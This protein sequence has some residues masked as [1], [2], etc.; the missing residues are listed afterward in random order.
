M[1]FFTQILQIYAE[2]NDAL[3]LEWIVLFNV[4]ESVALGQN[5]S[6]SIRQI[7][8]K[9]FPQPLIFPIIFVLE[10]PCTRGIV[11]TCPPFAITSCDPTI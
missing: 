8:V 10:N 6:A 7:C 4:A 1:G 9:Q 11:A 3:Y 2:S 5:K